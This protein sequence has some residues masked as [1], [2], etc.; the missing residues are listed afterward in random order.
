MTNI[1]A[2]LCFGRHKM[3]ECVTHAIFGHDVTDIITSPC[4]LEGRAIASLNAI[5]ADCDVP[6]VT[7]QNEDGEDVR[8]FDC[9]DVHLTIY[10]TGLSVALIAAINAAHFGGIRHI[11]LM[12]YDR[13]TG[14]YYS[15]DVE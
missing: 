11:T 6:C 1:N 4:K 15:Q 13:E 3:P 9:T 14:D 7:I 12:H 2:T 8:A 10:V 5:L